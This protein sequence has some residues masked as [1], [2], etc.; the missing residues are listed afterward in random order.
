MQRAPLAGL[1][2][3]ADQAAGFL[4]LIANEK[5]LLILCQLATHREMTVNALAEA[6]GLSQSASSQH[7]ARLRDDGLVTFRRE[8][9]TLYYRVADVR[10]TRILE[11]LRRVFCP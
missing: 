11:T 7:L 5:R 2:E 8:A 4:K 3:K 10:A 6:I 1:A 9:Q